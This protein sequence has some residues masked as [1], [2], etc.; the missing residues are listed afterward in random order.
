MLTTS[1]ANFTHIRKRHNLGKVP[2]FPLFFSLLR[3]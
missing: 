1:F 2:S 3:R